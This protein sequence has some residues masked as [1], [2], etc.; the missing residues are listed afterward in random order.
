MLISN[1]AHSTEGRSKRY[2]CSSELLNTLEKGSS[3]HPARPMKKARA[4]PAMFLRA[5][6]DEKV[7]LRAPQYKGTVT[8]ERCEHRRSFSMFYAGID[9]ADQ[10]HDGLVLDEAGR[11]LGSMHVP[12]TPEGLDKLD[13]WLS[14]PLSGQDKEQMACIIGTNH[15]LLMAF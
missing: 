13:A 8:Q 4:S 10:K 2:T 7:V 6:D 9:W 14:S 3:F 1:Q 11:K 12:H 15:G 5:T